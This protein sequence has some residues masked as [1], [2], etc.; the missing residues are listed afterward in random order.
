VKRFDDEEFLVRSCVVN[1]R[2]L[3]TGEFKGNSMTREYKANWWHESSAGKFMMTDK[4][5]WE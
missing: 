3:L 4:I 5:C 1:Q 2:G